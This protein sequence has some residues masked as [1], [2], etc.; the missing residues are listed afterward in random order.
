MNTGSS[1]WIESEDGIVV[2]EGG[3]GTHEE[4][5]RNADGGVER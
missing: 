1:I 4:L 5:L 3:R 2:A